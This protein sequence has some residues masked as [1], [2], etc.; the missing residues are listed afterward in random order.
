MTAFDRACDRFMV[1]M[2]NAAEWKDYEGA[3]YCTRLTQAIKDAR[4]ACDEME[5]V[6]S[7]D[8]G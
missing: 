6:I 5:R 8:R 4:S 1:A 2:L 7:E 3:A